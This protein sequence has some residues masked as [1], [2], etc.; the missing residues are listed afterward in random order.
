MMSYNMK[1]WISTFLLLTTT[2]TSSFTILDVLANSLNINDTV[3]EQL[4]GYTFENNII[5]TVPWPIHR[6]YDFIVVGSGS[7]G[8][9]VANRL[10]ENPNWRVLLIEAGLPETFINQVPPITSILQQTHYNWGYRHQPQKTACFG[11]KDGRCTLPR[12]KA[13]GGTSSINYMIHT[14][15]NKLDY[16]EWA[17]G[18]NEGWAYEDVLPYYRK[19]ETF[20]VPG[21]YNSS[22]HGKNGFLH[23][24]HVPYHSPVATAYIK[25]GRDEGYKILDYNGAEQIG[26]SY[27]QVEMDR[28]TRCSASKAYLRVNRPNLEIVIEAQVTKLLIDENKQAI[29]VEYRKKGRTEK[30]YVKKEVILSAG[31][32]DSAKLL[33]LSGIGPRDHLEELGIKVMKDA[34]VGYN[35]YEHLGFL[36]LNFKVNA[37]VTLV[38]SRALANPKTYRD[39]ELHRTGQL[40]VPGIVESIAFVRTKYAQDERPDLELLFIGGTLASDNGLSLHVG[41]GI[42]EV[43]YSKVFKP[44]ENRDAFTIWPIVQ[45]PRSHGRVK[46]K[47]KDPF[48]APIIMPNFFEDPADVEVILEGVK[49]AIN[50]TKSAHFQAYGTRIHKAKVPGCEQHE[51]GSDDYWRCAIRHLPATM[52][53][54]IGTA[55]MGPA[56]DSDAVVD[57]Q[58]RVHGIKRLRVVD[59]SIMPKIPVGHINAGIYMI[60]EKAADMIKEAWS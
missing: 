11:M 26:F 46:L 51:F 21:N 47:S 36:G 3:V 4:K 44:L 40:T 15:G 12:G 10:S 41:Y 13:L 6:K 16:D 29:G 32:I 37:P 30:V 18:G 17:E 19:S 45:K 33:M 23:V 5:K 57:P 39:Y 43:S 55:K 54:E 1:L 34:K 42:S 20:R 38:F 22:Y 35:L 60:G 48:A 53:H 25:A 7:G 59:A 27:L 24:E 14:R 8:S 56:S 52:D 2:V 28:G 49:H 9:P 58:L 50:I 31:S